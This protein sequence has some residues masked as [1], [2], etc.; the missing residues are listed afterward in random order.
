M[1]MARLIKEV[2]IEGH[3]LHALF[4]TGSARSYILRKLAEKAPRISVKPYVVGIGGKTMTVH[5]ECIVRGDI[6]GLEFTMKAIPIDEIGVV[7]GYEVGAIIGATVMEEWGIRIDMAKA[8][9]DLSGLRR[10]EFIEY[11][12][13]KKRAL[14]QIPRA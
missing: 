11:V 6:E 9:L 14:G 8:E 7:G 12:G 5:E 13:F 2:M 1:T 4:D 10:R 3:K